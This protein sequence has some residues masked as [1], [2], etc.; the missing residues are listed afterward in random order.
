MIRG[1]YIIQDNV[2]KQLSPLF[3]E[4]N[5]LSATRQFGGF[6]G[7]QTLFDPSNYDLYFIGSFDEDILAIDG[8][9]KRHVINGAA[10]TIPKAS[11]NFV[12]SGLHG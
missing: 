5:D 3:L 6:L 1:V 8:S 12:E 4:P 7:A 10:V 11:S 2:S 9:V